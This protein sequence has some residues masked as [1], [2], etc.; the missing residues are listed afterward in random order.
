MSAPTSSGACS[1]PSASALLK[2][3]K[4]SPCWSLWD[5]KEKDSVYRIV[6]LGKKPYVTQI[7]HL[8][9]DI[10]NIIE[11]VNSG[12]AVILVDTLDDAVDA[13]DVIVME[14]FVIV[15]ED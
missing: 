3:P 9:Y 6:I 10:E 2:F 12:E 8:E 15:D 11:F 7:K 13:A 5:R 14:D 4:K 1:T